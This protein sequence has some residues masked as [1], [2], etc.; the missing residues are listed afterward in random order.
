MK[1][2]VVTANMGEYDRTDQPHKLSS[3]IDY[4]YFT[5]GEDAPKG[6][7]HQS[8]PEQRGLHPRTAAKL[9]KCWPQGLAVLQDYDRVVWVD[10]GMTILDAQTPRAVCSHLKECKG[11]AVSPHFDGRNDIVGEA[12][13]RPP[14]YADQPLDEQVADYQAMGFPDDVGLYETGVLAW[15]MH[16]YDAERVGMCWYIQNVIW[17]YQD[18]VSLPYVLW[19][20]KF[21]PSVFPRSFRNMNWVIVSAHSGPKGEATG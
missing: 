17:S 10:A 2:A 13:I 1:L 16:D 20:E 11:L 18:Q 6:W 9:P 15:D 8:L 14:H 21:T 4:F 19:Q 12:E 7:I 5:D 3:D